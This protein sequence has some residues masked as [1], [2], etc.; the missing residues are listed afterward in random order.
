[1]A[2]YRQQSY[3]LVNDQKRDDDVYGHHDTAYK[4][5]AFVISESL[6]DSG[7]EDY[8]MKSV[9]ERDQVS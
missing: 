1:M 3:A 5:S 4:P 9:K 8:N 6:H 2:Q 7:E